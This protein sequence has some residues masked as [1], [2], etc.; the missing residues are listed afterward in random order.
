MRSLITLSCVI[1][2][3]AVAAVPAI[4]SPAGGYA[5]D[6][7]SSTS[8]QSAPAPVVTELHTVIRERDA[9]RTLAVVLAA[10]ALGVAVLG[11]GYTVVRTRRVA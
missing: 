11:A 9:G 3:L 4:A 1:A 6:P 7:I 5:P 10:T 8:D 2:A